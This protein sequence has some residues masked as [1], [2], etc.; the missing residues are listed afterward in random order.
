MEKRTT[1]KNIKKVFFVVLC[2]TSMMYSMEEK[3]VHE[4][5]KNKTEASDLSHIVIPHD[6]KSLKDLCLP[7]VAQIIK[8]D[9]NPR[10][11]FANLADIKQRIAMLPK[12]LEEGLMDYL[13]EDTQPIWEEHEISE[14]FRGLA[15]NGTTLAW[16]EKNFLYYMRAGK[17]GLVCRKR[18]PPSRMFNLGCFISQDQRY[19]AL[20]MIN[21]LFLFDIQEGGEK[22]FPVLEG[23]TAFTFSSDGIGIIGARNGSCYF[24]TKDNEDLY[25]ISSKTDFF[26]KPVC[27]LTCSA[28]GSALLASDGCRIIVSS[29][30]DGYKEGRDLKLAQL[31]EDFSIESF[32]ISPDLSLLGINF[33]MSDGD[34]W[35]G[36]RLYNFKNNSYMDL[37]PIINIDY[38]NRCV[39]ASYAEDDYCQLDY[40]TLVDY[41]TLDFP[42]QEAKTV[43]YCL[44]RG[45]SG[46]CAYQSGVALNPLLAFVQE[47]KGR[48]PALLVQKK[49]ELKELVY[50]T[51]IEKA[52]PIELEELSKSPILKSFE[53]KDCSNVVE[54]LIKRRIQKSKKEVESA[55]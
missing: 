36:I 47:I 16:L 40:T 21:A 15:L 29:K 43:T 37:D 5:K 25:T 4:D 24:M 19:I 41:T 51:A 9:V 20:P 44:P 2:V 22:V 35:D 55:L 53:E 27:A 52:S 23:I 49:C 11:P 32:H 46:C 17:P 45:Y 10:D 54:C 50:L 8:Q 18:L 42:T 34:D 31:P 1:M 33:M 30:S 3:F 14:T 28:N 26:S 7:K 39:S 6:P 13:G 48:K 38:A 12:D